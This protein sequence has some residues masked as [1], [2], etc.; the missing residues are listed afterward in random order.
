MAGWFFYIFE[1][2]P[3]NRESS[4][5]QLQTSAEKLWLQWSF[6]YARLV[7][8]ALSILTHLQLKE[9]LRV[10]VVSVSMCPGLT[11]APSA[12]SCPH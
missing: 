3:V 2:L 9:L 11:S 8:G 10:S 7:L 12:K 6:L 5:R 1:C 4:R